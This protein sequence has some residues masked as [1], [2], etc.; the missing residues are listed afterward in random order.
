MCRATEAPYLYKAHKVRR[1]VARQ[2]RRRV[3]AKA[4]S[5]NE[6]VQCLVFGLDTFNELSVWW[7][8]W[9][10]GAKNLQ[11]HIVVLDQEHD[12]ANQSFRISGASKNIKFDVYVRTVDMV[13]AVCFQNI[14]ICY[15]MFI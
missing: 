4:C 9:C 13:G 5:K 1:T 15:S 3:E 11:T 2:R 12:D 7:W 14:N 10:C 6:K 8:W